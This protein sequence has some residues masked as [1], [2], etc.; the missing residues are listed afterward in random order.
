MTAHP[1]QLYA[2][3][4]TEA[5]QARLVLAGFSCGDE[6][7]ARA[8]TEWIL[9]PDVSDSITR[10]GTAVWLFELA[11]RQVVGFASL[12]KT[13]WKWPLPDGTYTNLAYIP[14]V[15]LAQPFR[16][17]PPDPDWRYADQIMGHLVD[18]A[19]QLATGWPDDAKW[20]VLVV[21]PDNLRA[22]QFYQRCGLELI[23]DAG[24]KDGQ[25]VMKVWLGD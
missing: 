23:P 2:V 3:P 17:Q 21:H 18:Q 16:G 9:G 25:H 7:W 6:P 12:G 4:F 14:M 1:H 10:R 24:R 11:D 19:R 22:I 5:G 15:G 8:A 20:L 13:R